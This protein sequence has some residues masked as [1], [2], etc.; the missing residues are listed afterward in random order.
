M[1]NEFKIPIENKRLVETVC[2]LK[3]QVPSFEEFMKTYESDGSLNYDDLS[4][5]SVG[6]VKG[7]GPVVQ[8]DWHGDW[9]YLEIPCVSKDCPTKDETPRRWVHAS[10]DCRSSYTQRMLWSTKAQ[11]KC[12]Y[13]DRPSHI[14]SWSF[15]CHRCPKY[16]DYDL[17]KYLKAIKIAHEAEK[18]NK[19]FASR[20]FDHIAD[21]PSEFN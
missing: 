19:S 3:D 18:V 21:N 20:L 14:S 16:G 17:T 7:Y 12:I 15:K 1:V 5:G 8:S 10:E 6:E 4:G 9:E 13:C 2:E 11:I